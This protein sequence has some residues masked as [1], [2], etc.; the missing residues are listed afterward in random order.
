MM[1]ET[2]K[3]LTL[4]ECLVSVLLLSTFLVGL[5]GVF[6]ISR[7]SV[8]R[9]NH[10]LAAMNIVR[11]YM[12]REIA[13]GYGGDDANDYYVTVASADPVPVVIDDRGTADPSDDL[14]GTI[15]PDPYFPN[16]IYSDPPTCS[17]LLEYG[18]SPSES[19][20]KIVG[21][22]VEWNEDSAG[23]AIGG[24]CSERAVSYVSLHSSS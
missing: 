5:L 11:E 23:L 17:L 3:G 16:N 12:E 13:A 8:A 19:E 22:V 1:L 7:L 9:A 14:M 4:V 21:F 24:A 18:V 10:R 6:F 2:R 15:R 20:Y